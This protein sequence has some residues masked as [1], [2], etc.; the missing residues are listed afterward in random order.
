MIN[1]LNFDNKFSYLS[2]SC[3][4]IWLKTTIYRIRIII[5]SIKAVFAAIFLFILFAKAEAEK[6]QFT[7][8]SSCYHFSV[9]KHAK[10]LKATKDVC[11]IKSDTAPTFSTLRFGQ[12][13]LCACG[14]YHEPPISRISFTIHNDSINGNNITIHWMPDTL[15]TEEYTET[16]PIKNYKIKNKACDTDSICITV[17]KRF[18]VKLK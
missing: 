7:N 8:D 13:I 3:I 2:N 9:Y 16:M 11:I 15:L 14:P 1:S 5:N 10:T 6:Y 17:S 4:A 12:K 18:G